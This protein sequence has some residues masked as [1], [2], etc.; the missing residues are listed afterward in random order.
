M[1]QKL[2]EQRVGE[3]RISAETIKESDVR[4]SNFQADVS[5]L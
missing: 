4:F 3:S 2:K 1:F 5:K